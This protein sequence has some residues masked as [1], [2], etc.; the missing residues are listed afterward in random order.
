MYHIVNEFLFQV[1]W[2]PETSENQWKPGNFFAQLLMALPNWV[3]PLRFHGQTQPD[4]IS[5]NLETK[6]RVITGPDKIASLCCTQAFVDCLQA[7][8]STAH[9]QLVTT[10]SLS[11]TSK[12]ST[13]CTCHS[14]YQRRKFWN[15]DVMVVSYQILVSHFLHP[16][17]WPL[18]TLQRVSHLNFTD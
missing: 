6:A 10:F 2:N 3:Q 1:S 15:K 5:L 4:E 16:Q 9:I 7:N 14:N 8:V 17:A 13:C 11:P 12:S 18:L